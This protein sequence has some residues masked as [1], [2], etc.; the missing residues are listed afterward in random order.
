M[1]GS[2]TVAM[3]SNLKQLLNF[4][5]RVEFFDD[6]AEKAIRAGHNNL[7]SFVGGAPSVAQLRTLVDKA[8]IEFVH[9]P[10]AG[11]TSISEFAYGKHISHRTAM[12]FDAVLKS[13]LHHVKRFTVLRDPIARFVSAYRFALLSGGSNVDMNPRNRR[14]MGDISSMEKMAGFIERQPDIF[15]INPVF[16]PQS[17]YVLGGDGRVAVDHML[18]LDDADFAAQLQQLLKIDRP[19]P[20]KNTAQTLVEPVSDEVTNWIKTYYADDYSLIDLARRNRDKSVRGL[21]PAPR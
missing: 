6:I 9:V 7:L 16:R 15:R 11:G 4:C 13:D 18:L 17:W 20:H 1:T 3:T 8:A 14:R 12:F 10:R 2:M 5:Y 21:M 19:V